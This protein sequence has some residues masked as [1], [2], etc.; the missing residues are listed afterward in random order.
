MVPVIVASL[1][2]YRP[3]RDILRIVALVLF[4]LGVASDALD[5]F[6]ARLQNQQTELGALLD[7]IADK[8]L[9]LGTLISCSTIHGLP[10]WMRVPAWFNLV[11][12]SRDVLLVAGTI[13]LFLIRGRWNVRPS[14]LGKWTTFTKMLVVPSVL[15]GLPLR[16]VLVLIAATLTILSAVSYVR[17]GIRLLG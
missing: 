14:R 6:L 1:V 13:V 8:F 4:V 3:D 11:V 15:L 7:P 5:G 9:I 17:L 12:I 2:Y 16:H 10:A